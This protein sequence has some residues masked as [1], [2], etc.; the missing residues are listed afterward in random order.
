MG[1]NVSKP[2][3]VT[4][5]PTCSLERLHTVEEELC[6][7][8]KR[9]ADT[10][11][12]SRTKATTR[13]ITYGEVPGVL[14]APGNTTA[15]YLIFY[16]DD[17][18]H[19]NVHF[20]L[21]WVKDAAKTFSAKVLLKTHFKKAARRWVKASSQH[22][23][24]LE[25]LCNG[26]ESH[27]RFFALFYGSIVGKEGCVRCETN[28]LVY[29]HNAVNG[30]Y[31]KASEDGIAF[32]MKSRCGNMRVSRKAMVV[33]LLDGV[34]DDA[35]K[36]K[37]VESF[38]TTAELCKRDTNIAFALET[39]PNKRVSS[40]RSR[41]AASGG[42]RCG[43]P[44]RTP[45]LLFIEYTSLCGDQGTFVRS[46]A[47]PAAHITVDHLLRFIHTN[48]HQH[49]L[50]KAKNLIRRNLCTSPYYLHDMG[51]SSA[52]L[53][54]IR[55]VKVDEKRQFKCRVCDMVFEYEG[56]IREHE[57]SDEHLAVEA[58][59]RE[60]KRRKDIVLTEPLARKWTQISAKLESFVRPHSSGGEGA[61]KKGS[62][63][64]VV[65][66]VLLG[67]ALFL[68]GRLRRLR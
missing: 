16:N 31:E 9:W 20:E 44:S 36:E 34:L 66:L 49:L 63:R 7:E 25:G 8:R 1:G 37:S 3:A 12:S 41:M 39:N 68:R 15:P 47:L 19:V 30:S 60:V 59:Q 62:W 26:N 58:L 17:N 64:L 61:S 21:G 51:L 55:G 32:L 38:T 53:D 22:C 56:D 43:T 29:R 45:L 42:Q 14:T 5:E 35:L 11:H 27:Q 18:S 67:F 23:T 28:C 65:L 40:L 50:Y 57:L 33:L 24:Q 10:F 46:D 6:L 54:V 48:L 13:Q 52:Y 2:E 4:D